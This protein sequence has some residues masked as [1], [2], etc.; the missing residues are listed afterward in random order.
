M[1]VAEGVFHDPAVV[2]HDTGVDFA[3]GETTSFDL[4]ALFSDPD[5]GDTLSFDASLAGGAALPAWL[6]FDAATATLTGAPAKSD[7]DLYQIEATAT[8]SHGAS[9]TGSD[10]LR[11]SPSGC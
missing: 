9:T 11:C 6:A 5:T 3:A 4:S 10:W 2:P 8:D 7:A 1:L